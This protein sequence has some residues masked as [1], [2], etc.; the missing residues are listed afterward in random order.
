MIRLLTRQLEIYMRTRALLLQQALNLGIKKSFSKG[1]W[2]SFN[3][4]ITRRMRN[5]I[6]VIN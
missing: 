2:V 3:L 1:K 5:Y 4:G 6:N